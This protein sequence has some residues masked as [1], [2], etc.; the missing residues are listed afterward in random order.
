MNIKELKLKTFMT[1][2]GNKSKHIRHIIDYIPKEYNTYIEPFVGTGALFL[3]LNPKKWIINDL[4]KNLINI[5]ILIKN[6]SNYL[7]KQIKLFKNLYLNLKNREEEL[8]FLKK[9]LAF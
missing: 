1:R 8:F 6:D 9:K 2:M 3:Y 7:I 5:W 4:N